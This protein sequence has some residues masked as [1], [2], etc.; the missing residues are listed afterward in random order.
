[1]P[2]GLDTTGF[3]IDFIVSRFMKKTSKK[4]TFLKRNEVKT[5]RDLLNL[6]HFN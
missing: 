5:C 4:R 1:M 3:M 2:R 6:Q